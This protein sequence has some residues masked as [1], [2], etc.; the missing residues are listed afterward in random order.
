MKAINQKYIELNGNPDGILNDKTLQE[1]LVKWNTDTRTRTALGLGAGDL[2][3]V[4]K[5]QDME[6]S[7]GQIDQ[8]F[9]RK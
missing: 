7:L 3:S 6:K 2:S 5:Y 1:M 4:K 8:Q 9:G